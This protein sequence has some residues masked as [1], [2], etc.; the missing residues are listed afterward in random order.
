MQILASKFFPSP[1]PAGLTDIPEIGSNARTNFHPTVT[2]GELSSVLHRLPREKS[3]E[4][5]SIPNEILTSAPYLAADFADAITKCFQD[6]NLP[7]SLKE[8]TTVMLKKECSDYI[9]S[10]SYHPIALENSIA[11]NNKVL[12]NR[13]SQLAEENDLLPWNQMGTRKKRQRCQ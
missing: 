2:P 8:A 6:G 9:L 12:A 13:L 7:L 5:D 11:K 10:G 4:Q 3:P 1:T